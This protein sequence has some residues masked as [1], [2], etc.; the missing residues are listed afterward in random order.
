MLEDKHQQVHEQYI[1]R[2]LLYYDIF[3]YPLKAE[4]V[5]RF[6]GYK[7]ACPEEVNKALDRLVEEKCIYR[8]G[9]FYSLQPRRENVERRIRGN[10]EAAHYLEIARKKA[11][12]IARF[13]F[14]RAVMASGSLSKGY[15]DEHCDLDFFVVTAHGGLWVART[16]LVLY[17]RIFLFNSHRFFCINYLIDD[18]HLEIEEKNLYT[19]T[20]L[21]TVIP[22]YGSQQ[23]SDLMKKNTWMLE[24]FPHFQWRTVENVSA[25]KPGILKK[26][27]EKLISL[28]GG[29]LLE[30]ALMKLTHFR[31]KAIYQTR[32]SREEFE[33]AFKT[34]LY[35]SKNHPQNFQKRVL[36][37]YQEKL[38]EY[39]R[40]FGFMQLYD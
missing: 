1:I 37:L 9:E 28:L 10:R 23:Y 39:S 14:V 40:R 21:A 20:E 35:A 4:E 38:Q 24:Y 12:F 15:M 17:K 27:S 31:W 5:F 25:S 13:P 19:A 29:A 3:N 32:Y 36:G 34:K 33:V 30:K 22:L 18:Q 26:I 8:F 11:K 2:T 6:L 7:E 16:L